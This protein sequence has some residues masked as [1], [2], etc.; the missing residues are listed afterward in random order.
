MLPAMTSVGKLPAFFYNR[1]DIHIIYSY[2]H[3][4]KSVWSG[5]PTLYQ[6]PEKDVVN[7]CLNEDIEVQSLVVSRMD[8]KAGFV[9]TD[10]E[11]HRYQ[12]VSKHRARFGDVLQRA[13]SVLRHNHDGEDHIDAVM[14]V[15]K[16]LEV[17]LLDYGITRS[18]FDSSQKNYAHSRE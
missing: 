5:L 4:C 16:A 6:E 12:T 8:V 7:P 14:A 2:L 9:L 17:Y 1:E 10:P 11:D 15:T 18:S 13:A 3:I